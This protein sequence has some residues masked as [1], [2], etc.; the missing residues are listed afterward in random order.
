VVNAADNGI[1]SRGEIPFPVPR[2][3]LAADQGPS[4]AD[5]PGLNMLRYEPIYHVDRTT[6]ETLRRASTEIGWELDKDLRRRGGGLHSPSVGASG[7]DRREDSARL[8]HFNGTKYALD[9]RFFFETVAFHEDLERNYRW[10]RE[11]RA[12]ADVVVAGLHQ[13]GASWDEELPPDHMR[14][15]AHGAVDAGADIVVGHGHGRF[16]GV[17]VYRGSVIIYG[18]P[19]FI[20]QLMQRGRVPLEQLQ[21][22]GF[23]LD[24]TP[25]EFMAFM[26]EAM[27]IGLY[28]AEAGTPNPSGGLATFSVDFDDDLAIQRVLVHPLELTSGA[29]G[30]TPLLA[31]AGGPVAQSVLDVAA[32]RTK[33]HGTELVVR[34]GV[35]V[36]EV[37]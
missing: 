20:V 13:Q 21:R 14:V 27:A 32:A 22:F 24:T 11:A 8:F 3:C 12:N 7:L 36:I 23:G 34:D 33:R 10:I 25:S 26:R 2:G 9:D 15:F 4:F 30:G 28:P 17:E 6:V 18:L 19:G 31:E 16:G 29:T 1:R 35:G 37:G 5:R